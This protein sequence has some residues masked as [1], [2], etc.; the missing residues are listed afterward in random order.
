MRQV[1]AL[2]LAFAPM[3]APSAAPA[4]TCHCFKDRS[5]D[6]AAPASADAY[7]LATSSNSLLS[8][9]FGVPKAGLVRSLMTGTQPADLWIAHWAARKIGRD[10]DWLLDALAETGSWRAALAGSA[11]LPAGFERELAHRSTPS[12]LAALAVDDVLTARLGADPGV[13]RELRRAGGS[14]EELVVAVFLA[15]RLKGDPRELISRVRSGRAT[16]GSL[17]NDAGMS[18]QGIDLSMRASLR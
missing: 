2:V 4:V 3:A 15:Q 17:V 11:G 1:L 13:L 6:P 16:W 18:P 5:F 7:I 10:A 9:A 8:A 12:A 14:S